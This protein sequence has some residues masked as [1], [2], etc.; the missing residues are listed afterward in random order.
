MA[1]RGR[2]QGVVGTM[3]G[4]R[5]GYSEDAELASLGKYLRSSLWFSS[6]YSP[7]SQIL[8]FLPIDVH[9]TW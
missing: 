5:V 1:I 9:L 2:Q 3:I 6:E 7:S 4:V 8:R